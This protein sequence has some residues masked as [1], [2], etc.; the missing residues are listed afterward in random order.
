MFKSISKFVQETIRKDFDDDADEKQLMH[1][2][3]AA[4][5]LEV[6]R[7]DFDIQDEELE[8]IAKSFT[9]RFN[10]SKQEADSLIELA[11]TEQDSHVSIH[12]FVKIINDGC[13]MNEKI[14]LLEDL[15]R[16]AYADDKLDKYEE[17]QLRKIADL[18]YIPH[19]MFIKTKLKVIE[20]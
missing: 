10:F 15:W 4:L 19:S 11:R 7:A 3:S 12:P 1:L 14:L 6:S 13:S 2:A 16:V 9:E 20:S 5:L 17:Y 8:S 18:L